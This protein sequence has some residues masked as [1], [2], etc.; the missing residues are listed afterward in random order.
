MATILPLTETCKSLIRDLY[1]DGAPIHQ[2]E[3]D[4]RQ[5]WRSAVNTV[6]SNARANLPESAS[7]IAKAAQLVL[8]YDVELLPDGTA[9]VASQSNGETL[10][11]VVNGSCNCPDFPR[12][13][14]GQCKHKLARGLYIRATELLQHT[15]QTIPPAPDNTPTAQPLPEAPCSVNCH[16]TVNGIL[17][18]LTLRGTDEM[19]VFQRLT[20][21]LAQ[22]PTAQPSTTTDT[23]VCPYHGQ[24]KRS[25][26]GKGFY[27][28]HKLA[29]GSYCKERR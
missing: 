10:Y 3:Q 4:A 16:V 12:A 27:C 18:Q 26:K 17:A 13:P 2:E 23:P 14:G 25:T 1:G 11:R 5:A 22:Y 29:D 20:R 8:N 24:M 15:Q 21:V 9:E 7:R 19:E 6:A 28:S